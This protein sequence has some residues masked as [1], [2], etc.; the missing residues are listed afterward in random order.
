MS[1]QIVV[2][3][4]DGVVVFP[5]RSVASRRPPIRGGSDRVRGKRKMRPQADEHEVEILRRDGSPVDLDDCVLGMGARDEV[6]G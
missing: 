4:P 6:E 5:D 2:S 1:P 3:V